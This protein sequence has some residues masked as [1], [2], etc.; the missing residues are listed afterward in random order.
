MGEAR[1]DIWDLFTLGA[2]FVFFS[3]GLAPELA[4]YGI[5]AAAQVRTSTALV[6]SSAVITLGFAAYVALFAFRR[7]RD[8]GLTRYLAQGKA[9]E[10]GLIALVAF[11]ELPAR[12]SIFQSRTLVMVLLSLNEIPDRYLQ[13]VVLFVGASKLL[14]WS[15]LFSLMI[16]YH[17]FG[18]RRVFA[19][20]PS[21]FPSMHHPPPDE[22]DESTEAESSSA[23]GDFAPPQESDSPAEPAQSRRLA[24]K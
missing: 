14:A 6:N 3:I 5:R 11:L 12:G 7:C 19:E 17:A 21:L 23:P 22:P 4:F 8:T 18:N 20:V 24:G 16:R 2:W 1:R 13:A 9:L 15:Y 10:V